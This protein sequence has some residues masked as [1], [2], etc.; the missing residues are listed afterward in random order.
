MGCATVTISRSSGTS[1]AR[2]RQMARLLAQHLAVPA[3]ERAHFVAAALGERDGTH[4]AAR[5]A[6]HG[7]HELARPNLVESVDEKRADVVRLRE[8][9]RRLITLTG[10]GGV[11]K[12]SLAIQ[13]VEDVATMPVAATPSCWHL[14]VNPG[15]C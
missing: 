2:A 7:G 13:V 12:T 6:A 4:A 14:C 8:D 3:D 1:G 5:S 11:G 15:W 10:P 9:R